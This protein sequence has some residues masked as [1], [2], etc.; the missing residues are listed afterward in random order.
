MG[1]VLSES[2]TGR[3]LS[4][5]TTG[6]VLSEATT[7]WVLSET[8]TGRVLNEA[9]T[10]RML[11]EANTGRMF[12]REFSKARS[13]GKKT[14]VRGLTVKAIMRYLV[15]IKEDGWHVVGNPPRAARGVTCVEYSTFNET[16]SLVEGVHVDSFACRG[17]SCC[18]DS[19]APPVG[20]SFGVLIQIQTP[21]NNSWKNAFEFALH[22]STHYCRISLG[23]FG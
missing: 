18:Y 13:T 4:E 17:G 12:H 16:P 2:I 1:R 23:S 14:R 20:G 9:T 21:K 10:G 22:P 3:V 15:R 7:G 5:A 11:S 6:R 8:I 19:E